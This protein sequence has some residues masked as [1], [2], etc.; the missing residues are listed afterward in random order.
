M[1]RRNTYD[2]NV[3]KI[4][5]IGDSYGITLPIDLVRELGWKEKQKV[6]VK[7]KGKGIVIGDWE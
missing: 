4:A 3:R 5:R 1:A 6:V 2:K 7:K